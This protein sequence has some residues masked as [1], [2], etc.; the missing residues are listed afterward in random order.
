MR[1]KKSKEYTKRRTKFN[2][3]HYY[4]QI[5]V[6]PENGRELDSVDMMERNRER[7]QYGLELNL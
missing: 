3:Q 7:F 4:K 5:S 2:K 6:S 1:E